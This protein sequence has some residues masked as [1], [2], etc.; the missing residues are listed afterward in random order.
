MFW[1]KADTVYLSHD[2]LTYPDACILR[3]SAGLATATTTRRTTSIITCEG[4][5]TKGLALAN[6]SHPSLPPH[7]SDWIDCAENTWNFT[8]DF[9]GI[10]NERD[11]PAEDAWIKQLRAALDA[12]GY[13]NTRLVAKDTN[14]GVATDMAADPALAAAIDV[15]GAHY[16]SQPPAVAYTLNKTLWASEMCVL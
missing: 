9:M 14:W 5:P 6:T 3:S 2:F 13:V 10:W 1:R 7:C 15:V 11:N 8:V 12:A 4:R 16:P